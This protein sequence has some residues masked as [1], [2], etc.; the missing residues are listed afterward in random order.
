M[1]LYGSYTSPFVRHCRIAILES[2]LEC[3]FIETDFDASAQQSPTQKVPFLVDGDVTLNDSA[4]I[5]MYLR[6]KVGQKFPASARDFNLY[7]EVT[8]VLDASIVLM[9]MEK[10]D[11]ITPD[12][13]GYLK[14][15]QARVNTAL[16]HL[17]TL[18]FSTGTPFTD[19]ELRL[20]C[21]LGWGLYRQRFDLTDYANLKQF[22]ES[23]EQYEP[24]QQTRPPI[25]G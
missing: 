22:L 16:A 6:E 23:A 8:T 14:R 13:S 24:F 5:L 18:S 1:K 25:G 7:C 19:G 11:Q 20:A 9:F 4:S 2:N 3:E 10:K 15:N 12:Q 21:L 17:N